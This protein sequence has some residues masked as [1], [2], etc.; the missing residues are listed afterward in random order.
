MFAKKEI[1]LECKGSFFLQTLCSWVQRYVMYLPLFVQII[2]KGTFHQIKM[3][4]SFVRMDKGKALKNITAF[5][6]STLKLLC[7][8]N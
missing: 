6:F 7:K 8:C 2:L 3:C 1:L 4:R 5:L